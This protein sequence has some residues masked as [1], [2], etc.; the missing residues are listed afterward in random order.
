M[1]GDE[2][3]HPAFTDAQDD[4]IIEHQEH[5]QERCG[6][7]I[8]YPLGDAG[9]DPLGVEPFVLDGLNPLFGA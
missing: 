8:G 7:H 2:P 9:I 4:D 3:C 1:S 6:H 5:Q